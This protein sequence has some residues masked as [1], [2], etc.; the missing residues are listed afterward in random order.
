MTRTMNKREIAEKA[1]G[2]KLIALDMDGT[3][4]NNRS[5]VTPRTRKT[6]Q[7]LVDRGY[8]VTPATGRGFYGLRENMLQVSNIRYVIS[9]NGAVVTDA[10]KGRIGEKLIPQAEAARFVQELLHE[11]CYIYLHRYDEKSTHMFGCPSRE[12]YIK[13]ASFRKK[14]WPEDRVLYGSGLADFIRKDGRD[15]IKLGLVFE[16]SKSFADYEPIIQKE[17]PDLNCFRVSPNSLEMTNAQASKGNALRFLC[18]YLGIDPEQDCAIGDQGNDISM[19][20]YAGLGVAMGNAV[21]SLK[22]EADY[23]AGSNDEEGAAAFFEEF[24]L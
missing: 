8:I 24:F 3:S 1:K 2:I 7:A 21:D 4:L 6:I 10:E 20:S 18:E 19:V 16:K 12:A 15:V 13:G 9:A 11:G 17:F 22:A 23:I 5:E 14:D